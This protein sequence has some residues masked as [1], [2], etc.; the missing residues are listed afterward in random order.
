MDIEA[1]RVI[2]SGLVSNTLTFDK[3]GYDA[4]MVSYSFLL[5]MIDEKIY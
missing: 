4:M 3:S 2:K 5:E 1:K